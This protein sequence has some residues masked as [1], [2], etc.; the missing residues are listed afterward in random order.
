MEIG[1]PKFGM[2]IFCTKVRYGKENAMS[3]ISKEEIVHYKYEEIEKVVHEADVIR[4]LNGTEY[5]VKEILS[6]NNLLLMNTKTNVF[7]VAINTKFFAK[8]P[9][10][11]TIE[12]PNSEYGLE[13]GHG[14]Y[15]T[16]GLSEE[17]LEQVR[18]EYGD[19]AKRESTIL[20]EGA[21]KQPKKRN[22]STVL[23]TSGMSDDKFVFETSANASEIEKWAYQYAN[24]LEN[25]E[26]QFLETLKNEHYVKLLYDSEVD[27]SEVFEDLEEEGFGLIYDLDK[28]S[29][30]MWREVV[31]FR[32]KTGDLYNKVDELEYF[33]VEE[34][35]LEAL[36]EKAISEDWGVS[37]KTA[38]MSGSRARGYES[39]EHISDMDFVV[40][41]E[42]DRKE[43]DVFNL[44]KETFFETYG[45]TD[46][47]LDINPIRDEETGTL[48][49]YL[50]KAERYMGAKAL[51]IDIDKAMW[52]LDPY[53]YRDAVDEISNDAEDLVEDITNH[54]LE[55]KI[56]S[57]IDE[58]ADNLKGTND[59]EEQELYRNIIKR[60]ESFKK[61]TRLFVDMDGTLAEFKVVDTLEKLYEK[62]Y[63][64]NLQPN[65]NVVSAIE[66]IQKDYPEVE[67]YIMSSVLSD[68]KYA[69]TEKNEWL[70][71]YLPS[72]D[73]EHR[74]FP[75]CGENKVDYIP[76]GVRESDCLLDDYTQNLTLWQ[77][78]AKGIK[79]LN[80]INHSKG[81]WQ[82][83]RIDY[84]KYG[85]VIAENI[86]SIMYGNS[87]QDIAPQEKVEEAEQT[88]QLSKEFNGIKEQQQTLI[89][90]ISKINRA[91]DNFSSK[92]YSQSEKDMRIEEILKINSM[93]S[94]N[95]VQVELSNRAYSDSAALNQNEKFNGY[96]NDE[97][98]EALKILNEEYFTDYNM[99]LQKKQNAP[100]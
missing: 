69:L 72:I 24:G 78:P 70:D 49:E 93:Y 71:K 8:Y 48:A 91:I 32:A 37:F 99:E 47:R 28:F 46:I 60:L 57:Y 2:P 12:S 30:N 10:G 76:D 82:D 7:N 34:N 53:G 38:V 98:L 64:L 67:V 1:V 56:N 62:G 31:E 79:L 27:V 86:V 43:D 20:C 5:L 6:P 40:E 92:V 29:E 21:M 19:G 84:S 11:E 25:G 66:V 17:D 51:A 35:L 94:Y 13:W 55:G 41:Y 61:K 44:I 26:N 88:I 58:F 23:F 33:E 68:S 73:A 52:D 90:Q 85:Y 95:A 81:T 75:P 39:E 63:F 77:P 87:V 59:I 96:T 42:G 9:E 36:K 65:E 100:K 4:N 16:D 22:I 83:N 80:G 89:K 54:I 74:I 15:L 18:K 3:T 45:S 14:M 97:L 50:P